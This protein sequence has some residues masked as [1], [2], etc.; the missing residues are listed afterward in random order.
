LI[1]DRDNVYG[2]DFVIR[3]ASL[4]IQEIR[5]PRHAPNANAIAERAVRTMRHD[6]LDHFIVV[7]ERLWGSLIHLTVG[8]TELA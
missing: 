4:G 1:R 8:Y 3:L 2:G 6:C 7:N 5:T